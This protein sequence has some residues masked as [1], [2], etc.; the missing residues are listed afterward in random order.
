MIIFT[1]TVLSQFQEPL[2]RRDRYYRAV[3]VVKEKIYFYFVCLQFCA[4]YLS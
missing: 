2:E 3:K 4:V 1:K